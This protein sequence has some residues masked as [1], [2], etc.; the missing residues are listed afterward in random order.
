MWLLEPGVRDRESPEARW[1]NPGPRGIGIRT[2]RSSVEP[3]RERI[4]D[5]WL[6]T[7]IA[8][9]MTKYPAVA[10]HDSLMLFVPLLK[11]Y[12]PR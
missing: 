4:Q 5:Y 6:V 7:R 2:V 3:V 8:S 1:Q 10:Q 12:W 9:A 11:L